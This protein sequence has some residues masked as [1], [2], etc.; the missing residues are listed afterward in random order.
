EKQDMQLMTSLHTV[1][2]ISC[3]ECKD[4]LVWMYKG[5]YEETQKIQRRGWT[6]SLVTVATTMPIPTK[7]VQIDITFNPTN[8]VAQTQKNVYGPDVGPSI[9]Q[10]V[11]GRSVGQGLKVGQIPQ[12]HLIVHGEKKLPLRAV[13]EQAV[14]RGAVPN[15][16]RG[17]DSSS[18]TDSL[19]LEPNTSTVE[20]FPIKNCV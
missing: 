9:A 2:D 4:V 12:N 17:R 20:E 3:S 8:H 1:A 18:R 14:K 13:I 19:Q 7:L 10:E 15:A 5:A 6:S 16:K 11:V